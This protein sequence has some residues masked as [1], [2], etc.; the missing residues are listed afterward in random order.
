MRSHRPPLRLYGA[1]V[2]AILLATA[3]IAGAE[4]PYPSRTVEIT[5]P[6]AP[7]GGTDLVAR[8]LSDGLSRRLGQAF[9]AINRPGA[10][11]NLGTQL[12]AR[13]APDGY[14][15]VMAASG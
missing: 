6:F 5:V 4:E 13:A 12:V 7:G 14:S 15:L 1:V 11:T 10:N 8:L 3:S 9:V 2:L